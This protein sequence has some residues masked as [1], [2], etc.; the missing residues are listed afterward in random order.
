[1]IRKLRKIVSLD[2][3][4]IVYFAH[5]HSH[6]SYGTLMWGAQ[7]YSIK[8]F[9]LQK[10][11]IRLMSGIPPRGHC[12]E[13][14]KYLRIMTV[15]AL[16]IYQ[17]LIYV[18]E[19]YCNFPKHNMCHSYNTRGKENIMTSFYCYTSTLKSFL[20]VSI[21]LFNSLPIKIKYLELDRFKT[22]LKDFLSHHP[23]YETSE[24]YEIV[25]NL[26]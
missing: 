22:K 17:C 8:L 11:G 5:I 25:K 14:F 16:F 13:I 10:K 26:S 7:T 15:P 18:K 4:K 24:F 21:K 19:N 12:R 3:L 23:I 20:H 1:M 9:R 6:L 2:V